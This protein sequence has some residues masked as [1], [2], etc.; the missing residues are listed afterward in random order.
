MPVLEKYFL[1]GISY[2][3]SR[4][5]ISFLKPLF[6]TEYK[7]SPSSAIR[8]VMDGICELDP[9]PPAPV[10]HLTPDNNAGKSGLAQTLELYSTLLHLS[11][12][13]SVKSC[14]LVSQ[15]RQQVR[16][17]SS[18]SPHTIMTNSAYWVFWLHALTFLIR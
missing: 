2:L 10:V 18:L 17:V 5:A 13:L 7:G 6:S 8:F 12:Q 9:L 3:G 14:V 15:V 11:P 1:L 4:T 16:G